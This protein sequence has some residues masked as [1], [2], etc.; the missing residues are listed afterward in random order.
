MRLY[1]VFHIHGPAS[2]LFFIYINIT[3]LKFKMAAKRPFENHLLPK[4][5]QVIGLA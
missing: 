2:L 1:I 4:V 3:L 5:N